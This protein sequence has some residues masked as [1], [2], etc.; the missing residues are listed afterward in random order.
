MTADGSLSPYKGLTPFEDS[1]L[2][3]RFF[4]GRER[5][6][7]LI[8]ANLMASRLTVL[9]G[10]TGVGKSSVLRAGVAHH[11][12][13]LAERTLRARGE[14]GMAVVVFDAWR[15]DP[16]AGLRAAVAEAVTQA[17]GG[18]LQPPDEDLPLVEALRMWSTVLAGDIYVV[19]DQAEEYFLYHPTDESEHSFAVEFPAVVNT[20]DLRANF[21]LAIREDALAKLDVFKARI[22]NVLGNYLRLEHLDPPAARAAIVEPIRAYNALVPADDAV[23]IEPTLVEAVLEQVVAGKVDV[24]QS[25]RG[26]VATADATVRIETAYLQLVMYRLWDEERTAGSRV[27]RLETLH[28]LGGAEQIVRDHVDEALTELTAQEKDLAARMLDHLVTP[29]GAKIAHEVVDLAEYAGA[30]E[31]D[32]LPV[33][34]KLGEERI[35][36]SVSGNGR[37]GSGYEIYHDVLAEPVLAWKA[38]YD[39]QR[40]RELEAA[41]AERRHRRLLRLLAAAVVALLV[42]AAV[43]A[44]AVSQWSKAR[45]QAQLAQSRQLAG[46]AMSD[47]NVDPLQSL[48]LALASARLRRTSE[49]E[50][51]LRQALVTDRQRAILP[52]DGPVR[53]VAYN[54][55]GSLVLTSSA[56]GTARLWHADGT[57]AHILRQ[58]GSLSAA[59]FSPDGTLVVT[60]GSDRTA[61]L[62]RTATGTPLTTLAHRG[63]VTDASFDR[64]GSRVVT[65]SADHALRVW[66][67]P[68]GKL[69]RAIRVAGTPTSAAFSH[70]GRLLLATSTGRS[71]KQQRARLF[72]AATGR[73]VRELPAE[74]VTT[75]AFSPDDSLLVTGLA[76]GTALLWR[77]AG[78]PSLHVLGGNAGAITDA[79]FSPGGRLLATTSANG[80]TRIWFVGS[81]TLSAQMLGHTNAVNHVAFSNDAQLVVTAGSDGTARVWLTRNGGA[82]AVL[83][84]PPSSLV[85]DAVF[86]PDG[87]T[88]ATAGSDGAARLWDAT[89]L[90]PVSVGTAPVLAASFA[91][92]GRK[93]VSAAEDG[94]ARILTDAGRVLRVLPQPAPVRD[95]VFTPDGSLVLTDD[96]QGV[97]RV[98]NAATGALVRS[99]ADVSAGRLDISRDGRLLT[100]PTLHGAIGVWSVSTLHRLRLLQH[101]G[102]YSAA[103]FSPDGRVI[104][105]GGQNGV[106]RVLDAQSGEV[107]HTLRGHKSGITGIA[108][109]DDGRLLVTASL[110]HDARIWDVAGGRE[111]ELL[112][113]TTGSLLDASFSPDGRW[114][115]TAGPVSA[116]VWDVSTGDL[117]VFLRGHTDQLTSASFS[118]DGRRILTSSLDNTVRLYTCEAC[119]EFDQL[120]AAAAGRLA[121]IAAHLTQAEQARFVPTASGA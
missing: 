67:V 18:S 14:P 38:A 48:V 43:T 108:F 5:E 71:A 49:A 6:R 68:G 83:R 40:E 91:P 8:E 109:S 114:V 34:A 41:D 33:L 31:A 90:R 27:L 99:A 72:D 61:R 85:V 84:G 97:L 19:L 28:R 12:R 39:V 35:L 113:G 16:L 52:S 7:E 77:T 82:V 26:A 92:G 17:L 25:G 70:D 81:G 78:G 76:D 74:G 30:P 63:R 116:G 47:L 11:L 37:R 120:V 121:A 118:P 100:A 115:V 119:G 21:L 65:A 75:A 98:W 36:R 23:E 54:T 66:S 93:L 22:P 80:V 20:P 50:A 59:A 95:A 102:P 62:W 2:D 89:D 1:E 29:S 88:V 111:T 106:A 107:K 79:V 44:F 110:D 105:A 13:A 24:G 103:A 42:M 51:V 56:D 87:D 94:T 112:R 104:A 46:A 32:V 69:L 9:Y 73:L 15:D 4:F 64:V 101:G 10:E 3:V 117:I 53:T 45:S 60:G 57:P 96:P 86:N 55:D 58:R